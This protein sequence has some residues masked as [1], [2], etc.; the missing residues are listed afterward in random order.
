MKR[1]T[2]VLALAAFAMAISVAAFAQG[3]SDTKSGS[4]GS[5]VQ[6][7]STQTAPVAVDHVEVGV[8][9]HL[10]AAEAI[11]RRPRAVMR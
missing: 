10:A 7:Q 4:T 5:S 9:R 2:T 8:L 11:S 1:L 3:S 6:S